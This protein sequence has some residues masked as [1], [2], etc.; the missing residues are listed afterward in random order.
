[1][2]VVFTFLSVTHLFSKRIN[3]INEEAI[4]LNKRR[5]Q[6]KQERDVF[7]EYKNIK[8]LDRLAVEIFISKIMIGKVN[9][10]T[11][12]R[13]INIVWNICCA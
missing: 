10:S 11:K 6:Q 3:E 12:K 5:E 13:A 1:M 9:Q 8:R 2:V 4:T 7:K